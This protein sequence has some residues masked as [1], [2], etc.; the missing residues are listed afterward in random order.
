MKAL[1][2]GANGQVGRALVEC[3]PN[4]VKLEA[5][6]R[7]SCDVT[8][9]DSV[10]LLIEKLQPDLV[11]N[12]TAYTAVDKAE[13]EAELAEKVNFRAP[14]WIAASARSNGARCIHIS[15]DF[16]FDGSSSRPYRPDD[17]ATPLGVYGRT[18]LDGEK[19]VV[20]VHPEALIVR[21]SWVYAAAG[22]NF[23][24]T[25]LR[26]MSERGDVSVVADQIGT[27]T[28]ARSLAQALW[29]LSA[30]QLSGIYHFSDAGVAS[31]YDF[32]VAIAEEASAL[33]ILDRRVTV[34]PISTDQ[35]P[36]VARR[37][38]FS[39]LDKSQTWKV[40]GASSEHWRVNLRTMLGE[41]M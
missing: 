1:I 30:K 15:T 40:L 24:K 25:M 4:D 7:R 27:P 38:A 33:G 39:V 26:L 28:Y 29:S 9:E 13:S 12:A 11:I 21:T 19:A 6:D 2:L 31:W 35:F 41:L 20:A 23:V 34:E 10:A 32:A 3:A 16:V 17:L 36:T 18:K 5:V 8:C 14:G 22:S 37:P